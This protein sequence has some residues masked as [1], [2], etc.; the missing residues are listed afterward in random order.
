MRVASI[1]NP[2]VPVKNKPVLS[3]VAT[4]VASKHVK[5]AMAETSPNA[6]APRI[7]SPSYT[8]QRHS[9]VSRSCQSR[10]SAPDSPPSVSQQTARSGPWQRACTRT[11]RLPAPLESP[12]SAAGVTR[13]HRGRLGSRLSHTV[14]RYGGKL[15]PQASRRRGES[16]PWAPRRRGESAPQAPQPTATWPWA[17]KPGRRGDNTDPSPPPRPPPSAQPAITVTVAVTRHHGI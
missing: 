13:Q 16:A 2:P 5:H 9:G 14:R 1:A 11:Y 15:V 4:Q 12:A 6:V 8:R 3:E 7:P 17:T 10:K